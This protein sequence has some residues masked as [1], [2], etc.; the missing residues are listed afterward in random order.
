MFIK[1]RGMT[2]HVQQAGPPG[3]PALVLLH[4]LGANLHVW[5]E[6][7]AVLSASLRVIRFDMRGHGLSSVTPGPYTIEGLADDVLAVMDSLG[8]AQAHVA[9]LSIGG[10]IA[11]GVAHRAPGRVASLVLCDT[12]LAI[13]PAHLWQERAAVVRKSGMPGLVESVMARW[14]T[15]ANADSPIAHGMRAMLGATAAE[16]YAACAEAIGA[17]TGVSGLT[18][19]TLVL[20]GTMDISTPPAMA[21]ALAASIPGAVL[22]EIPDAAHIAPMEQAAAVTTA[23]AGFL[24]A[25]PRPESADPRYDAGLAVRREVLGAAHV[26]RSLAGVTDFD[27]DWQ[28]HITRT[29]WGGVWTRPGFDRRTRS[30]LT[31]AIL[32]ALGHEEEFKLHLNATRNTG[33]SPADVSEMLLHISVYAGVPAANSAM[34]MAKAILGGG[35]S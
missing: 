24:L 34:R 33:T 35:A 29:A 12:A 1:I 11:Q 28:A 9:G 3:A 14:I 22:I 30:L 26:D 15:P 5:D 10:L 16:G 18:V 6:Q 32:A 20:V 2:A 21:A 19:P 23:M 17:W 4:S 25:E 8:V 7:V 31:L 27:R 13:P